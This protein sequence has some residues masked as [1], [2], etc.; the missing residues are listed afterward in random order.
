MWKVQFLTAAD[1]DGGAEHATGIFQHEI[2]H[3]RGD[4]LCST[5][6]VAF[7]LA[8]FV[9]YHNDKPAFTEVLYG[10]FYGVELEWFHSYTLLYILYMSQFDNLG[11][12]FIVCLPDVV[13]V[14]IES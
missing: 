6:Q 3:F 13:Q 9:V 8:V 14:F 11:N 10:F 4:F 2:H 7:V 1:G 5:Y 12:D